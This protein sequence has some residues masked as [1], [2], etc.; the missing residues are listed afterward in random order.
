[1]AKFRM[2]VRKLNHSVREKREPWDVLCDKEVFRRVVT[3]TVDFPSN[4]VSFSIRSL[5]LASD[6]YEIHRITMDAELVRYGDRTDFLYG[7]AHAHQVNFQHTSMEWYAMTLAGNPVAEKLNFWWLI[8]YS[9]IWLKVQ[10]F[11]RNFKK[12]TIK[13]RFFMIVAPWCQ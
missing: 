12:I 7:S 9:T 1:M 13:L 4:Y 5:L 6:S 11:P 8:K 2:L 3:R 10:E